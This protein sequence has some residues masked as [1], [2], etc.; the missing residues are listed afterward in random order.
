MWGMILNWFKKYIYI[1]ISLFILLIVFLLFRKKSEKGIEDYISKNISD[2]K[3][4]KIR[5]IALDKEKNEK[6]LE[7]IEKNIEERDKLL[8]NYIEDS[9]EIAEKENTYKEKPLTE[10]E[11]YFVKK[12]NLK[13]KEQ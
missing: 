9:I 11:M 1:P 12:Y 13:K 2:T 8:E 7:I 3:E 4:Q 5:N 6:Q 10:L